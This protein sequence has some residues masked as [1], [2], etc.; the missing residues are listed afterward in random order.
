MWERVHTRLQGIQERSGLSQV[1]SI[2]LEER[3]KVRHALEMRGQGVHHRR[4]ASRGHGKNGR[5][6]E[7]QVGWV[8]LA[9]GLG[10]GG[11]RQPDRNVQAAATQGRQVWAA[12]ISAGC[13][14]GVCARRVGSVTHL[15]WGWGAV[16]IDHIAPR[17]PGQACGR[18]WRGAINPFSSRSGATAKGVER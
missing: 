6:K 3:R 15:S 5:V 14:T 10:L 8:G 1:G 11:W 12:T 9:R 18:G 17:T 16:S 13:T 7:G 2:N 4:C